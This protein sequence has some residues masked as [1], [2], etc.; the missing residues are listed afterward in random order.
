MHTHQQSREVTRFR[1]GTSSRRSDEPGQRMCIFDECI[2]AS[3]WMRHQSLHERN[4]R[5]SKE[6]AQKITFS[7][8]DGIRRQG[9][10]D[11]IA[12]ATIYD[13]R[14]ETWT[15]LSQHSKPCS[16]RS[17]RGS[18]T[19]T[20]PQRAWSLASVSLRSPHSKRCY[21]AD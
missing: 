3:A 12:R 1:S 19:S 10:F 2:L 4:H 15:G 16:I 21:V 11:D 6:L 8:D 14:R 9:A 18:Y 13:P 7:Y 17:M 5:Q 20:R